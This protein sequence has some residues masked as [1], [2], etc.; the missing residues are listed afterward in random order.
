[1]TVEELKLEAAKLG[2]NVVKKQ[3]Y[4]KLSPCICGKKHPRQWYR[5]GSGNIVYQCDDCNF[6]SPEAKTK[7]Q[8]RLNW[9]KAVEF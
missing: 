9:N 6:S 2:Y 4:I 7:K 8:A 1:M 3:Q 5:M